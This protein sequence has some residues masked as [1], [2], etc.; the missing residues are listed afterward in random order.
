MK[1][2]I[3]TGSRYGTAAHH[4]P[5]LL[6][7]GTCE[8]S[9]V[10]LSEEIILN[11]RKYY[12]NK[13]LKTIRIGLLGAMNGIRIRKWFHQDLGKYINV[14][15]LETLC[16]KNQIPFFTTP[17]INSDYTIELFKKANADLGLSLGNSYIAQKVFSIPKYGMINI[18]HEILPH[19]QNAQSVIWQL[20]NMSSNTGYT[21]HKI[22][23]HIDAGEIM[24]QETIPVSF[25]ESLRQTVAKTTALLLEASAEGLVKLLKDFDNLYENAKPQG[26][27]KSYTTPSIWQFIKILINYKKLKKREASKNL[28]KPQH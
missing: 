12:K 19:Y 6:Q 14:T 9:M 18:H 21:I 8:I 11:K 28:N 7:S 23:R 24:M 4:L 20:Y 10:V 22:N 3:L 13:I 27:G 17:N 15:E 25:E 1:V 16:R 2:I 26:A 5:C